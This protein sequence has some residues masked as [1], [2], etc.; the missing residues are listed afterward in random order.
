MKKFAF[1]LSICSLF[2]SCSLKYYPLKG[3]YPTPP[4]IEHSD[5]PVDEVWSNIIDLF[6]QKGISIKII[7]KSSGLIISTQSEIFAT[8]ENK[9]G[10]PINPSAFV[11]V[12]RNNIE[13]QEG[14]KAPLYPVLG[15]WNI[16]IKN[17]SGRT[18]INVNIVNITS[19][20]QL[21]YGRVEKFDPHAHTTGVFEKLIFEKIK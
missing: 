13:E 12:E 2:L 4:I 20:R 16:R 10:E 1:L 19:E 8:F 11:V 18:S 14:R 9:K 3:T 5:K 15:E 21:G 7:D 17:D 6:S